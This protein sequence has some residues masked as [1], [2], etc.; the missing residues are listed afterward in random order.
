MADLI[1]VLIP[2][3]NTAAWLPDCLESIAGQTYGNF[4]V[5]LVDDGSFDGSGEVCDEFCRSDS[6]FRV[7]H[8][9]N[10]GVASARNVAIGEAKG[11]YVFFM[12][13]D[14]VIHPRAFEVLL[15]AIKSGPYAMATAKFK[16]GQP[17]DVRFDPIESGRNRVLTGKDLIELCIT[18]E[19]SWFVIWNHL[20]ARRY[21][22]GL[23]FEPIALEDLLFCYCLY[24]RMFNEQTILVEATTYYYL[25]HEGSLS[26]E[27]WYVNDKGNFNVFASMF[28]H[29]PSDSVWSRALMLRKLYRRFLTCRYRELKEG[30]KKAIREFYLPVLRET[31]KEYYS[32]RSIP[33]LE[34][35]LF[36]VLYVCPWAVWFLM[37]ATKN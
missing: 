26:R 21:V 36:S 9:E 3:Y 2:V 18:T 6:R 28:R 1:S 30:N 29:T 27:P 16:E 11:D 14:D 10:G 31:R 33:F 20:I 32:S 15:D 37:K 8:K 34:K 23:L 4:E 22:E 13:S 7:I 25:S 19:S 35:V 12:D 5:I 17:S 24:L